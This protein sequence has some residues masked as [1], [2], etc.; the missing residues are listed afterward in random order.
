MAGKLYALKEDSP[1]LVMDPLTLETEGY[2][3][4]GGRMKGQTFSAHSKIDPDT[5]NLCHFGYRQTGR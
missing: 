4:F 3:D 5:G 1:P 2:S